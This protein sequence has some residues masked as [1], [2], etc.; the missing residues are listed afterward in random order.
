VLRRKLTGGVLNES[1]PL[2]LCFRVPQ[3]EVDMG[4]HGIENANNRLPG[5]SLD[6]VEL[7]CN[8]NV[9]SYVSLCRLVAA[10]PTMHNVSSFL[11]ASQP[12]SPRLVISLL[13]PLPE[14]VPL[15]LAEALFIPMGTS[16]QC[17]WLLQSLFMAQSESFPPLYGLNDDD[18]RRHA[19]AFDGVV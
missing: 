13:Q 19:P 15:K 18:F 1:E 2:A 3:D 5:L 17:F 4:R 16:M 7:Y 11:A 14:I 8:L 9:C 12:I 6:V 10:P